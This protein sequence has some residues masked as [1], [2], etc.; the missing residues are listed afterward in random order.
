MSIKSQRRDIQTAITTILDSV[1]SV[2]NVYDLYQRTSSMADILDKF[3][4]ATA[5]GDVTALQYWTV[6]RIIADLHTREVDRSVPIG[7]G[8]NT[9]LTFELQLK[10]AY[11]EASSEDEFQD[12]IDDVLDTFKNE[13]SL[14]AWNTTR[15]LTMHGQIT[16]GFEKNIYWHQVSFRVTVIAWEVDLAP[17]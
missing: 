15:P 3:A 4:A 16:D 6:R 8:L 17:H 2:H 1:P 10:Y 11:K 5:E 9:Y 12:L 13:R 14:G 7:N